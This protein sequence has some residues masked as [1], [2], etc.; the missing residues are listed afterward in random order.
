MSARRS[1]SWSAA[2][3]DMRRDR[4]FVTPPATLAERVSRE[5]ARIEGVRI[6]SE[7]R[8][9]LAFAA[10]QP[11]ATAKA[12]DRSAILKLA[13]A[14]VRERMAAKPGQLAYRDLIGKAMKQA[15]AAARDARRAAAH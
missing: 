3:A 4:A 7:A 10:A 13:N 2:T 14:I 1:L 6:Y 11:L 15:W 5:H 9:A 12:Y 8:K